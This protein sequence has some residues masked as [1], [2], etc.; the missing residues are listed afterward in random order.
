MVEW[1]DDVAETSVFLA[2]V[3]LLLRRLATA[4][5]VALR[6]FGSALERSAACCGDA[7]CSVGSTP[8]P[9]SIIAI[10]AGDGSLATRYALQAP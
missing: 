7:A 2:V 8:S 5:V 6:R 4:G 1:Q 3:L 10:G 9:E